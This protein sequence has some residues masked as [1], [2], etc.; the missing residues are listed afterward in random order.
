[1]SRVGVQAPSGLTVADF[2]NGTGLGAGRS[3]SYGTGRLR[4]ERLSRIPARTVTVG[5]ARLVKSSKSDFGR[6]ML[7]KRFLWQPLT[8]LSPA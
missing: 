8:L 4:N 1:M 3:S 5:A 6:H 7:M 2:V